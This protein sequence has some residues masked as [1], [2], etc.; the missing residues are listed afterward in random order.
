[1]DELKV[2]IITEDGKYIDFDIL[3]YTI[4]YIKH[5]KKN[6]LEFIMNQDYRAQDLFKNEKNINYR[7]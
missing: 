3:H 7:F 6:L 5:L 1:M 4:L 2:F